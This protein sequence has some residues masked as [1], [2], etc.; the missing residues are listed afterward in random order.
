MAGLASM[1]AG[2]ARRAAADAARPAAAIACALAAAA[3]LAACQGKPADRRPPQ[4]GDQAVAV[5]NDQTIWASDVKREAV[6]EGVIAEGDPFDPAS[7]QFRQV[8]DEVIDT[9]VLA[10][11]ALAR[12]LD[13]DPLAQRRLAAARDRALEDIMV[14]SVVSK[15]VTPA[16]LN[17][18]YQEYLKNRTPTDDL[19]LRQIVTASE[20]DADAIRKQLAAGGNFDAL[21]MERSTD[22][23]SRFKGGDIG[24]VALDTL[25]QPLADALRNAKPGDL[26]GPVMVDGGWA[27]MR[28]DDRHPEPAPSLEQ[29]K[30][31]LIRFLTYDQIKDLVMTLEAHAK[32]Q[33]LLPPP[34]DVPGA[35]AEP[36]SA[37]PP[38]AAVPGVTGV[39][40]AAANTA[41]AA[42][43]PPA[44]QAPASNAPAN[45]AAVTP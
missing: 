8:L 37:P 18:L 4:P 27:V 2:K 30:P 9:R 10:G 21:A 6:A 38:G 12:H 25:P 19:H 32:I 13:A 44:A 23:A 17:A 43:P 3:A 22:A 36:A 29:V 5:V 16:A 24:E 26:V 11:E 35:P 40:A 20:P 31:Q 28:V 39:P 1:T 14:D 41:P 15:A 33:R 42:T 7:D 34:P 45:S